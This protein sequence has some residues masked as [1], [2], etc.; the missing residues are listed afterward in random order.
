[1]NNDSMTRLQAA[2][3]LSRNGRLNEALREAE[4]ALAEAPQSIDP[5]N[6][7]A[8]I[9][10]ALRQPA[11]A[12]DYFR[13]VT[14]LQPLDA[15]A[16]RRL[17]HA[18]FEAGQFAAAIAAYRRAI[19]LEPRHARAH[20]NLGRVLEQVGDL[21][22]AAACYGAALQIDTHYT[23]AHGNL[24]NCVRRLLGSRQAA[25]ALDATA[26][27]LALQPASADG[28][29]LR[30]EAFEMLERSEE[31]LAACEHAIALRPA[32]ATA[33][34]ARANLRRGR[35]DAPG[36]VAGFREALQ[37]NPSYEPA[38]IGAAVAEIPALPWSAAEAAASLERFESAL[39]ALDA[40][41]Q[42][43]PCADATALVGAIQPFYLAYQEINC[44]ELLA[45]HGRICAALMRSW[46]RDNVPGEDAG[47][48]PDADSEPVRK[49]GAARI[50]LR[51]AFVAAQIGTHAVYN[52]ITRGWLLNLDRK[53]FIVEV[54]DLGGIDD[55]ETVIARSSA[56]HF[57]QGRRTTRQWAQAILRRSPDVIIY[58]E[59]GMDQTT[60]QLAALRLARTQ[61]VSWGHPVTSGLPTLD[62]FLS[63]GAFEPADA[64]D[65][66]TERL[67]A[68]PKLGV[69]Q[70]PPRP[71]PTNPAA[72]RA[73]GPVFVCAGTPFKY[74]PRHDSVLTAIAERLGRCQFHFFNYR[75]GELTPRL[76]ERLRQA[77]AA[78]GLR[79]D[80]FLVLRPWA[81]PGEFRAFLRSADVFLDTLG[82]SGFN[83]VMQAVECGLPIVT[84]RGRF[85]R[86]RLGSGILGQL[87]LD[88]LVA[89][90]PE[91]Y[92]DQAVALAG[93]PEARGRVRER[94][95]AARPGLYHD[96]AP[97][98]AL[99]EFL[100]SIG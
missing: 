26:M 63:A 97:L 73:A 7:L 20:N 59:V 10:A 2:V 60:L 87:S 42:R 56:D 81:A 76:F 50:K 68:L 45:D 86:G 37:A 3:M 77:F 57:E 34:F 67:I 65:H 8:E 66:Y 31:A 39:H 79:A 17:A 47:P 48:N 1:M 35:G 40:D 4:A 90:S 15:A 70:D 6:L 88:D 44:R 74:A 94:L 29:L 24:I 52:A 89:E 93:S 28:W 30:G 62:Y 98:E 19:E 13:R 41:L 80:D 95:I 92:V 53:R 72:R 64:A 49:R 27:L 54:F 91:R 14:R 12:A 21:S 5:L 83:T 85:M 18:E 25:Q 100:L 9:H 51:V 75:D 36:A 32:D 33:L 11:A 78:A 22:G 69:H 96:A 84:H 38:R 46:R 61:I 82:F 55:A 43:T 23:I 71:D 99:Q 16:H 58:P